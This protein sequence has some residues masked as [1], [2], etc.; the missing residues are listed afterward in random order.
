MD[1]SPYIQSQE[2]LRDAVAGWLEHLDD[3]W[4]APE[5]KVGMP[6]D[7]FDAVVEGVAEY[8]LVKRGLG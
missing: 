8:S 5:L 7:V 2:K 4:K 1:N 3:P 6:S